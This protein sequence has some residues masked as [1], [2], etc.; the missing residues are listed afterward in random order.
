M[1]AFTSHLDCTHVR[2]P[3]TAERITFHYIT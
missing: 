3:D 1:A 2:V